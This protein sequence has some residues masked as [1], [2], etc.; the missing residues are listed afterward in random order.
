MFSSETMVLKSYKSRTSL[1][2]ISLQLRVSRVLTE[3]SGAT[4]VTPSVDPEEDRGVLRV[5][6][7]DDNVEVETVLAERGVGVPRLRALE[8]RPHG[9]LDLNAGVRVPH[10]VLHPFPVVHG[11]GV[12]ESHVS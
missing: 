6:L 5:R 8:A 12:T 9:V 2:F 1:S 11:P 7:G 3:S 4:P 10:R